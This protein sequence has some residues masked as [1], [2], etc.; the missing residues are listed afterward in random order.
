MKELGFCHGIENYSRHLTGRAPGE[1]PPTLLDYLP[2]ESL[3]VI[4]ESHITIPQLRG[5]YPGGPV[6][7]ADPGR[8]RFPPA[9]GPGQPP[10]EL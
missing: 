3:V 5:M 1:P 9:L 10:P 4:D 7:E 6:P 2:R 8:L